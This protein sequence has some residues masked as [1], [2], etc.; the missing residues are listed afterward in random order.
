MIFGRWDGEYSDG[1]APTR[2]TGSVPIL[3]RWSEGGAQRVRYGQ[4]WV[5]SAVACTSKENIYEIK[6]KKISSNSI[7]YYCTVD[8]FADFIAL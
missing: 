1:V 5:F 7:N 3:R 4:C 6:F 2:W 8:L